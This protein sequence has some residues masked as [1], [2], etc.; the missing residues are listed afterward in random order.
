MQTRKQ[1]SL[2]LSSMKALSFRN[3]KQFQNFYSKSAAILANT[4]SQEDENYLKDG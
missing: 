2:N 1:K 4:S 3:S